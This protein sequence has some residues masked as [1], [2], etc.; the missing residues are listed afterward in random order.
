MTF[1]YHQTFPCNVRSL[2]VS[3]FMYM[4]YTL[5]RQLEENQLLSVYTV[6]EV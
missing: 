4:S 1:P 5:C 3:R 6:Y 2:R